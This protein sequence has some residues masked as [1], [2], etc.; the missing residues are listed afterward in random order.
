MRRSARRYGTRGLM[1]GSNSA[2][3]VPQPWKLV[4]HDVPNDVEIDPE[5]ALDHAFR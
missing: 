2:I 5:V 1:T 4:L 3:W